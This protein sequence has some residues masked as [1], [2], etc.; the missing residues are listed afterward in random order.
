MNTSIWCQYITTLISIVDGKNSD[1]WLN[2]CKGT[3]KQQCGWLYVLEEEAS[4]FVEV[5]LQQ[6]LNGV[7]EKGHK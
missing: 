7:A 4:V 1:Y 6:F 5:N 3:T 2:E